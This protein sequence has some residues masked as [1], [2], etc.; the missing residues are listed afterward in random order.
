M[1]KKVLSKKD[2]EEQNFLHKIIIIVGVILIAG[3]ISVNVQADQIT[4][5]FKSPSFNGINTSSHYLTIENQE[6]NR[7]QTIKD[8]LKAAIEEAERDKENSTVQRFIRNFESCVYAEL[9]R[10]LIANLFGEPP[11]DSGVISLEGNTIEYSPD[12]DFLTLRIT[13]ADGTVTVITIPIGSFTF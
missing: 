3:V 5:K 4:H 6:F 12:G 2:R 11:S 10:Q 7:R 8:E 13:E 1:P 9:S